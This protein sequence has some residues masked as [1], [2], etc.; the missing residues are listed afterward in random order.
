[1]PGLPI[2]KLPY[3]LKNNNSLTRL[4]KPKKSSSTIGQV[5]KRGGGKSRAI[6]VYVLCVTYVLSKRRPL[7]RYQEV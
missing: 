5:I 6:N 1:M 2:Q 3:I 7:K 4:G